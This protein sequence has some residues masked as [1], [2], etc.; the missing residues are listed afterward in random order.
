MTGDNKDTVRD[1][2]SRMYGLADD[3]LKKYGFKEVVLQIWT[4]GAYNETTTLRAYTSKESIELEKQ[5]KDK[6]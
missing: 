4:K 6:S 2:K 1:I 5:L 3:I